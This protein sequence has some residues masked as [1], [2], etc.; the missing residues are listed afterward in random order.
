LLS[1]GKAFR[2]DLSDMNYV[3]WAVCVLPERFPVDSKVSRDLSIMY[4][5][6][7]Q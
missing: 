2:H 1:G 7:R 3:V 5:L 4:G 6:S